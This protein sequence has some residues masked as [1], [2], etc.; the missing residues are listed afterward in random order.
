MVAAAVISFSKFRVLLGDGAS[1]E[2]FS[3]PCGFNSRALNRAKNLNEVVIPDCDDEDEPAW[4]GR[5]IV[6]LTWGVTG[7]GVLAEQSIEMWEDFFDSTVSRSVRVEI[8]LPT[9]ATLTKEGKAHLSTFNIVG[10]RGE[11]VTV[12]IELAGDGALVVVGT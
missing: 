12:N 1:P 10:N 8:D 5:E 11:K 4:V 6:S 7:D 9:Q 2:V 3:A